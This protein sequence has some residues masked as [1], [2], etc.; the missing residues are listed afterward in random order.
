MAD[1]PDPVPETRAARRAARDAAR[2]SVTTVLPALATVRRP[3]AAGATAAF[4]GLAALAAYGD[5]RLVLAAAIAFLGLVV[6][7]G[8]HTLLD[9]PS[10]RGGAIVLVVSLAALLVAVLGRDG[11]PW[12]EQ[13]PT[14]LAVGIIA[15]FLHQLVRKDGRARLSQSIATSA[16][17][18]ALLASGVCLLPLTDSVAGAEPATV[19]LG[20]VGIA[21]VVDLLVGPPRRTAWLM[22]LSMLVG[23]LS[24]LAL[25]AALGG[26]AA[27]PLLMGVICA[28]TSHALRRV[29][30]VL[31]GI[32]SVQ[33]Q[34]TSAAASVLVV[35]GLVYT[36]A[37]ILVG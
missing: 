3:V 21:A 4:A 13:V 35:G 29:L 26:L 30:A 24:A 37:R 8:W 6:I 34:L 25:A 18:L 14:A 20:A 16:F 1:T 28:G 17:G 10:A 2:S 32:S 31:P 9:A 19:G 36:V 11:E 27:W 5:S 15:T 7:R 22:P 23:G 12:L 33:G